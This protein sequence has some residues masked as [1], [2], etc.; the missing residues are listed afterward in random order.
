MKR[1]AE[2]AETPSLKLQFLEYWGLKNHPAVSEKTAHTWYGCTGNFCQRSIHLAEF[3]DPSRLFSTCFLYQKCYFFAFSGKK[4]SC[5]QNKMQKQ[6][7][8]IKRSS[9]NEQV[10]PT[11]RISTSCLFY[12]VGVVSGDNLRSNQLRLLLSLE[13]DGKGCEA[14]SE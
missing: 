14:A 4:S 6:T 7:T 9:G 10:S 8:L 1:I 3:G 5:L 2:S 13:F 11:P 12:L